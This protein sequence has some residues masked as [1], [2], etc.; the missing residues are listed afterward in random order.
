[1]KES[2]KLMLV[3]DH[4]LVRSGLKSLLAIHDHIEVIAE[5]STGK[6]A[7]E[8]VSSVPV[9]I[10]LMDIRM[11]DESGIVACRTITDKYPDIKV[12]ML[13][14]YDEDD[15]IYDAIV[16]GASGYL[17][18]EI[19]MQQLLQSINKLANGESLLDPAMTMKVMKRLRQGNLSE[20]KDKLT[21]QEK[22]VLV[23]ISQ[24]KT[25]REIGK[26]MHLSE[27][28]IRNYLSTIFSKLEIHNRAEAA[29]YAVRQHL[30]QQ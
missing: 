29:A 22:L 4:K 15:M 16:A 8:V 7:I 3:D 5:A 19:D 26:T 21:P 1:M 28:T 18:K 6:E 23:Y 24:G 13:T 2:V 10:I 11:P 27:K 20:E 25:N 14:S 30:D 12:I 17:L 9:D